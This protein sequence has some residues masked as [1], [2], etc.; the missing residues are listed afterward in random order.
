MNISPTTPVIL[1]S[2]SENRHFLQ[3]AK[4]LPFQIVDAKTALSLL[5]G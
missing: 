2:I 1:D 4:A 3:R 5:Q